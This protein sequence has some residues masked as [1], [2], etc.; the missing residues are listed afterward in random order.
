MTTKILLISPVS[1]NRILGEDF[2]F[3]LPILALPTVAAYTP[4]GCEVRMVDE[5]IQKLDFDTDADLVGITSMTA[6]APRAYQIADAFKKRG[7]TVVMGGMHPSAMP[8]EALT[9]CDAVVVG[10]GEKIWPS[11]VEDF[12]QGKLK[13]IY[14]AETLFDVAETVQPRWD[15]IDKSLYSPVDFIETTRGVPL[16]L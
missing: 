4:A 2:F 15:I 1:K 6:L 12:K 13:R 14:R 16:C 9:H 11:L 10:E 3:K 8:E 7:K 5:R